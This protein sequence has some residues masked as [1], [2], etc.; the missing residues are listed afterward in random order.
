MKKE[1]EDSRGEKEKKKVSTLYLVMAALF[2]AMTF[3]GTI[4]I[5]I[6]AG[7]GYVNFGDAVIMI[8]SVVLGPIGAAVAGGLGSAFADLIGFAVYAPFTLVIKALEGFVC[9]VVFKSVLKGKNPY[10]RALLSFLIGAAI[11]VVGYALTD[12]LLVLFGVI[13]S[14]ADIGAA[15]LLAGA[16]TI[17]PSLIQVGI[18]AAVALA[19]SP[20]LPTLSLLNRNKN[21]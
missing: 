17:V 18:S 19:V 4:L 14:D 10:L 7:I 1:V 11:V 12:I 15:A 16:A 20:K 3:V 9:G 21:R 5:R 2:T 13:A 6:P 8:A